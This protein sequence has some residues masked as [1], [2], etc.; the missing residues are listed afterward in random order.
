V[1][2][3]GI[4]FTFLATKGKSKSNGD[5]ST[6]TD[7]NGHAVHRYSYCCPDTSPDTDA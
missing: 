6:D 4:L 7:T 1:K 5:T 3:N 2:L